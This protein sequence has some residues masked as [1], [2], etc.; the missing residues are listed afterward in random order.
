MIAFAAARLHAVLVESGALADAV[1]AGDEQHGVLVH[2]GRAD[3][4][5]A[6]LRADAPDAD[7]VAALVAQFLL[8]EA[9]AHAVVRDE[10]DFVE[11]GGELAVDESVAFLDL[12]RDDAAFADVFEV[13]EVRL[14]HDAAA[15]REDDMQL[16]APRFLIG[17]LALDADGRGDFFLG[18]QLEEVRDAA[19]FAGARAFGNFKDALDVA[20]AARS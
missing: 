13:A 11:A 8:V 7:R 10:H 17:L 3:D 5:V 14:F 16:V 19:A 2:E 18:A 6:L 4:V 15:G 20:A 9:N 12:D 1:F